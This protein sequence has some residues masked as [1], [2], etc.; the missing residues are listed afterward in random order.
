VTDL[1]VIGYG[2]D[3]RS[4][5]GAG[6]A[7]AEM[8]SDLALPGVEVRTMSQLTPELTLEISGRRK[9]VFVD[10]DVDATEVTVRPVTAGPPG[11]GAMTHHGDPAT[12]L[13]LTAN[14][15]PLPDEALVVSIPATNLEM[16]FAFSTR[17]E[18]AIGEAVDLIASMALSN[19]ARD[20]GS[21]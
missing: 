11:G 5:D 19:A 10:A 17:T 14:V 12:L 8:V 16:G 15:G 4:D 3:L 2:N 9:V 18:L 7:V 21:C 20:G 1:L 13:S 6:R